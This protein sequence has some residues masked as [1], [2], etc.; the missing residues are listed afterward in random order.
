MAIRETIIGTAPEASTRTV[1]LS[2]EEHDWHDRVSRQAKEG[3]RSFFFSRTH[4]AVVTDPEERLSEDE[5][6]M[7]DRQFVESFWKSYDDIIIIS[8]FTQFGIVLR[9]CA[10]NWFRYVDSTFRYDDALFVSLPLNCLS[11]WM[12]GFI[13]SGD[14]LM[15][16]IQTRFT[17][18]EKHQ[19]TEDDDNEVDEMMPISVDMRRRRSKRGKES[20]LGDDELREVQ[21]L[22][23]ERRIR[24]SISL[25]LFPG[26]KKSSDVVEHYSSDSSSTENTLGN[27]ELQVEQGNTDPLSSVDEMEDIPM[28]QDTLVEGIPVSNGSSTSTKEVNPEV[29]DSSTVYPSETTSDT[30][31]TDVDQILQHVGREISTN[32]SRMRRVTLADGWDIGTDAKAMSDDLML[33]LR[34]GFCG[35]LSSF[36]SWNSSMVNLLQHRKIGEA[37]VGYVIG[38]QL[39]IVSYRF[40]QQMAVFLFVWRTRRE[41]RKDERRGY[42]LKLQQHEHSFDIDEGTADMNATSKEFEEIIDRDTPSVRAIVTALFILAT[43]TQITSLFFFTDPEQHQLALSLLFS[44]FGALTRWRLSRYNK[45]RKGFP[46][47]T[48]A[49]NLLA[50]ALSGSLGTILAGRPG[51]RERI[52]LVSMISGFGGSLSSLAVFIVETLRGVDPLLFRFNGFIYAISTVFWAMVIGLIFNSSV[53]WAERASGN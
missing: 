11:C 2:Q 17:P 32:I 43:V 37:L 28:V 50:C 5:E 16:V 21:L 8:L 25:A 35:A 27:L 45:G 15:D 19:H 53:D 9:L 51:P 12:M 14:D 52:V 46:L 36:S 30:M 44:P 39:P 1:E 38:L 49:C 42:G 22:A 10:A 34:V 47:G 4:D 24:E 3:V 48:F 6:M 40:G 18:F 7:Q 33:G 31:I 13:S 23:L 26:E 29:N 41:T 20:R